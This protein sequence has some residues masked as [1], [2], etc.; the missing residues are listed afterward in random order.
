MRGIRFPINKQD[1]GPIAGERTVYLELAMNM[2]GYVLA[3]PYG[4]AETQF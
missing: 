2:A 3:S 1:Q 4:M